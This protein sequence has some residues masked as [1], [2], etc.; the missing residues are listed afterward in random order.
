[1]LHQYVALCDLCLGSKLCRYCSSL[2]SDTILGLSLCPLPRLSTLFSADRHWRWKHAG[3]CLHTV[4]VVVFVCFCL[5]LILCCP[6][7]FPQ[8]HV[9]YWPNVAA[10]LLHT[11]HLHCQADG[12]LL[13]CSGTFWLTSEPAHARGL[14]CLF[15]LQAVGSCASCEACSRHLLLF[16]LHN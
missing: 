6:A 10:M 8:T 15:R 3:L 5:L 4:Q 16:N 14:A 9:H 11:E 1:M 12:G 7:L 2:L 13:Y